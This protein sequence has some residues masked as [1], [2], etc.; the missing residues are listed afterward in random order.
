M[1]KQREKT[2]NNT[3]FT[4]CSSV[5]LSIRVI[6][7]LSSI[8]WVEMCEGICHTC[9]WRTAHCIL[10]LLS[11]LPRNRGVNLVDPIR[12]MVCD[13][14]YSIETESLTS[15][16]TH[17]LSPLSQVWCSHVVTLLQICFYTKLSQNITCVLILCWDVLFLAWAL[18]RKGS[19]CLAFLPSSL[20]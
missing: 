10:C 17:F 4:R 2:Y 7:T 20:L 1:L 14:K 6:R 15:L 3:P 19:Q 16:H 9:L 5:C 12:H 8:C 18:M 13:A 11:V